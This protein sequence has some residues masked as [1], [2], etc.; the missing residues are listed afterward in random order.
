MGEKDQSQNECCDEKC[1]LFHG[2]ASFLGIK[3]RVANY[4][5][6]GSQLSRIFNPAIGEEAGRN[7]PSP[8]RMLGK[9][10]PANF[11]LF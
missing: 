9:A 7:L 2:C 11:S 8:Q 1:S 3:G 5:A 10:H 6:L 4:G